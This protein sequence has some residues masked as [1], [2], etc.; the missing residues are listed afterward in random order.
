MLTLSERWLT[1][2]T[3]PLLR[4]ATATGS[5]PTG[6][7]LRWLRP[8]PDNV[9]DL[10]RVVGRVDRV[11]RRAVGRQGQGAHE[12][13]FELD[14]RRLPGGG[15][16]GEQEQGGCRRQ[17]HGAE[18]DETKRDVPPALATRNPVADHRSPPP[19]LSVADLSPGNTGNPGPLALA[20]REPVRSAVR[21]PTTRVSWSFVRP[22]PLCQRRFAGAGDSWACRVAFASYNWVALRAPDMRRDDGAI[23]ARAETDMDRNRSFS[24][25]AFSA[26]CAFAGLCTIRLRGGRSRAF[27]LVVPAKA[28]IQ[29][30]WRWARALDSRF[31]GNDEWELARFSVQ[32]PFAGEVGEARLPRRRP[33]RRPS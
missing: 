4:A 33:A 11:E 14:E 7:E 3:S 32:R 27:K 6:T 20:A 28:G 21:P 24:S 13:A 26:Q 22:R 15:R 29:V 5:M 1:T 17:S 25:P 8:P 31:R 30:G 18:T 9:E 19:K 12:P 16:G 10:Q 2:Q 23:G